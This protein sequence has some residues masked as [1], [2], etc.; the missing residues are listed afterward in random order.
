MG[1]G[2]LLLN[3]TFPPVHPEA[4][5]EKLTLTIA[6]S[7]WDKI[8]GKP[9]CEMEN[10]VPLKFAAETVTLVCELLLKTTSSFSVCPIGTWP[11]LRLEGEQVNFCA[12]ACAHKES[13]AAVMIRK[14][15]VEKDRGLDWGSLMELFWILVAGVNRSQKG[16]LGGGQ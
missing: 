8:N 7:P 10:S 15:R 13:I 4:V 2:A 5:G 3:T 14:T 16:S 12:P 6:V 9:N 1:L 11:K